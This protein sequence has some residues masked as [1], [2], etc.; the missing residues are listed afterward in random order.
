MTLGTQLTWLFV[1]AIPVASV[2]WTITHEEIFAELREICMKKSERCKRFLQRKFFYLF[3]C[4]YCFSHYVAAAVVGMADFRLLLP[5]W[6]GLV[7]AWFSVVWVANV[8]MS[9]FSRL[10]LD[11]KRER[12]ETEA[13]E[14]A[15][16]QQ[17]ES[18]AA[19]QKVKKFSPDPGS[20]GR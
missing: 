12:V 19:S 11:I 18:A 16:E 9:L 15:V 10:R 4:E 14:Q 17:E 7:L 5:D 20:R 6:R 3:T 13:V 1:L 8:Y 2:A